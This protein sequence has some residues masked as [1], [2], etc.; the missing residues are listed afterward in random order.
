MLSFLGSE[1]ETVKTLGWTADDTLRLAAEGV[2][3][4]V[5]PG[6]DHGCAPLGLG[7]VSETLVNFLRET[8]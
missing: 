4:I 2:E 3:V 5:L 7:D 1:D 6:F 8:H